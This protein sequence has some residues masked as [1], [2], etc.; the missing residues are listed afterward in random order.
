MR[1]VRWRY[2][3]SRVA[4]LEGG[5][6]NRRIQIEHL[7]PK[8]FQLGTRICDGGFDLCVSISFKAAGSELRFKGLKLFLGGT[9]LVSYPTLF[10]E[11]RPDVHNRLSFQWQRGDF[12][13]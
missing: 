11:Q 9:V 8:A 12:G 10:G 3:E 7:V 5:C 2:S 4:T 1:E 6:G 13:E